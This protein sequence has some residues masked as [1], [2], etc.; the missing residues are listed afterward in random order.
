M[1]SQICGSQDKNVFYDIKLCTLITFHRDLLTS[2]IVATGP[3]ETLL[4]FYQ[5]KQLY[6]RQYFS[7]S[8]DFKISNFTHLRLIYSFSY[9]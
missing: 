9:L 5:T 8:E 2:N 3:S 4:D 7:H 6:R 1:K